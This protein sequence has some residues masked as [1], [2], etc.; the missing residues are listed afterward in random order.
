MT[1]KAQCDVR[2]QKAVFLLSLKIEMLVVMKGSCCHNRRKI[3]N[4]QKAHIL[5]LSWSLFQFFLSLLF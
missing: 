3:R 5:P 4:P 1:K 2:S